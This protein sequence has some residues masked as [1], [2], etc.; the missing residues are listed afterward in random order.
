MVSL[1]TVVLGGATHSESWSCPTSLVS[2]LT[3]G[4]KLIMERLWYQN[5]N[6]GVTRLSLSSHTMVTLAP[7]LTCF[8]LEPRME[9]EGLLTQ[10]QEVRVLTPEPV[11]AW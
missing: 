2:T 9:A 10:S 4:W 3:P 6:W 11:A 7:R 8:S 1:D 5:T